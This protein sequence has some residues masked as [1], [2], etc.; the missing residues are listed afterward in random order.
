MSEPSQ[1]MPNIFANEA[2]GADGQRTQDV[3]VLY[4]AA[5]TAPHLA[6]NSAIAKTLCG[7]KSKTVAAA[8]FL[9]SGCK[10]CSKAALKRGIAIITDSDGTLLD[11]ATNTVAKRPG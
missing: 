11:L 4:T 6:L 1:F 7:Q 3:T 10:K 8:W 5:G 2:Y 9:L